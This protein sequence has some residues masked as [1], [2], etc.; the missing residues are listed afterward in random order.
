MSL[1]GVQGSESRAYLVGI[2][3]ETRLLALH[4]AKHRVEVAVTTAGSHTSNSSE[5]VASRPS[6]VA[7]A[8]KGTKGGMVFRVRVRVRLN[9]F[10]K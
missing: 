8:R 1:S 5:R 6:S 9:N 10:A 2:S 3:N 7:K 4:V